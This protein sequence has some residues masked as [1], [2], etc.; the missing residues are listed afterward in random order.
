[1]GEEAVLLYAHG[2]LVSEDTAVQRVADYRATLLERQIYPLSFIWKTDY[3][4][5]LTNI[6]QDALRK[7]RPEGF[8]DNAK[9]FMLDRLDDAL[10]P[11]ARALTGKAQWDEMKQNALLATRSKQGALR[12][13]ADLIA[14]LR[15]KMPDLEVHVVGHS[16]GSILHAPFISRLTGPKK[17]GGLSVPVNTCTLWAPAC[18]IKLFQENYLPAIQSGRIERFALF[19]LT[20]KAEQDDNCAN[21][22]HKSLLYLVSNAF[23]EFRSP[24]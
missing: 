9:D 10:E 22:Y 14:D 2:G 3:W 19:T 21:I 8:L 6:V 15:A 1:M 4:S 24:R 20:D 13:V 23:E 18:T 11:I 17:N 16:A 5:T 7:R 12:H